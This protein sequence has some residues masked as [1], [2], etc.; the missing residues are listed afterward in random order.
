MTCDLSPIIVKREAR[1]GHSCLPPAPPFQHL[2]NLILEKRKGKEALLE[3][4][5][6]GVSGVQPGGREGA[7]GGKETGH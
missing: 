7:L 2:E 1:K 4:A 3:V 6:L 5:S